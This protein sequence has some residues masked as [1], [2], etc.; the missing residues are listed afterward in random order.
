[1]RYYYV[2]QQQWGHASYA[3]ICYETALFLWLFRDIPANYSLLSHCAAAFGNLRKLS[4]FRASRQEILN[5]RRPKEE[6]CMDKNSETTDTKPAGKK[7][8][9]Q[10]F[11]E[12]AEKGPTQA[13]ETYEKMNAATI[14]ASEV[15]KNSYSTAV[16]GM[17]DYNNKI[18]EFAHANTNAAFDFVQK[19]SGVKSPAAFI[20]LWTEHSRKQV[21]TLTEQSKELA[22]LTQTVTLASAEPFK[23]GV[24]GALKRAA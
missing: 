22:A 9:P 24:T 5:K 4:T 7:D 12:I 14:E 6:Y 17:Q 23:T 3:S 8:A 18:I 11:R 1:M 19:M 13:N 20:E 16:K 10:A 2:A 21:E 15:I